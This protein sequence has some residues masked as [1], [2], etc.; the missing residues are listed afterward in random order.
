[1]VYLLGLP[2]C[3]IPNKPYFNICYSLI[4]D[5]WSISI[6]PYKYLKIYPTLAQ[7]THPWTQQKN[8]DFKKMTR[9][10]SHPMPSNNRFP[11]LPQPEL[12][13][14]VPETSWEQPPVAGAQSMEAV[15]RCQPPPA[16][17]KHLLRLGWS[18]IIPN[19]EKR[20]GSPKGEICVETDI[21]NKN[22]CVRP[23][24]HILTN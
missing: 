22:W 5:S 24:H 15:A 21:P 11:G 20:T 9:K 2:H 23:Y 17:P 14:I 3:T 8:R 10:A 13:G 12:H 7:A 19:R 18:G 6:I 16:S 1:M 4:G